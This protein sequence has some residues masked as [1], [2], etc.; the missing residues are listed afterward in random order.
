VTEQDRGRV[1]DQGP[2]PDRDEQGHDQRRVDCD[3]EDIDADLLRVLEGDDD[4]DRDQG[5]DQPGTPV[6]VLLSAGWDREKLSPQP[7]TSWHGASPPD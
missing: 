7:P 5:A 6:D 1:A 3:E 2:D 4:D